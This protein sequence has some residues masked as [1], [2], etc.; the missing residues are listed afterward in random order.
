MLRMT[1]TTPDLADQAEEARAPSRAMIGPIVARLATASSDVILIAV[2]EQRADAIAAALQVAAPEAITVL[3]PPLDSLPGD[4]LPPSAGVAGQ[5]VAALRRL[6]TRGTAR[7]ILVTTAEAASGLFAPPALY[8]AEQPVVAVG[9]PLGP[10]DFGARV[11]AIGYFADDR[12]D[13]PG[14][15]ALRGSVIDLFAAD[16]DRPVRI[17]IAE[18]KVVAIRIYDPVT[19][20]TCEPLD[21]LEIGAACEPAPGKDAATLFDH[22]PDAALALDVGAER[23]RDSFLD[24]VEDAR[25]LRQRSGGSV[26]AAATIEVAAWDA[27]IAGRPH[28]AI[29][30]RGEQAGRRFVESRQPARLLF[31]AIRDARE[32]GDTVLLTGSERDLRFLSRRLTKGIGETPLPAADWSMVAGAPPGALL[33][34]PMELDHGWSAD[35]LM[36]VA[37]TD[38]LGSRAI[39]ANAGPAADPLTSEATSFQI[40]DAVIHED[41]GLGLLRG[42]ERVETGDLAS[43]AIRIEYAGGAQRLVPV[44]EADRLWRYGADE[45]AV[46]LDKLDGSSWIKR[47]GDIDAALAESA[48]GLTELARERSIRTAPVLEAPIAD[49]EGFVAG[50]P[51]TPTADQHRAIEAVRED[52][53]RPTPMDRL[54][55]GDVGYGKTEVALRAA[56]VAVLAGHQVAIVAPT[57]VLV[58]QHVET[59]RHRFERLGK[60]V[61]GLSGLNSA[62][63]IKAVR[64]GLADGGIDIVVGTKAVAAKGVEYARLGLVVIDEEQRFGT[65][66]KLKLRALGDGAHVLTLTATPIPR[67][68]QTALVGLHQ[69]SIIATPPARRQPIRTS[70]SIFD[71]AAARAALMREKARHG[72][73]FVVVPRIED[74]GVLAEQLAALVP[75]L[76]IRQAHGK[77]PAAEIDEAMV[78]FA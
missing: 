28:V 1:E 56:A 45:G 17:D 76:T 47:R 66:D 15:F 37:A 21:R 10:A 20:R 75:E 24:L 8:A 71:P 22:L 38:V 9:D 3:L 59:F 35:G 51:F 7:A 25:R 18:G 40:G 58:R 57:T 77:M 64:Q 34:L 78:R 29:A 73:S 72:Q 62:A 46:T 69:I 39:L 30:D 68:L 19:Q 26:G 63:E 27:A 43:D 70:V 42:I 49:Y 14:E 11:E 23:R 16:A 32:R 5:R 12:V 4:A 48:R 53:A 36:V 44:Q 31:K 60:R 6:R 74:M 2:D 54:V 41:H 13:E 65:A 61:E 50:F 33:S 52:L 67:T 55:V